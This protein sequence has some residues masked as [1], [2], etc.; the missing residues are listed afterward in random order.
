M[1]HGT[2][3]ALA[4]LPFFLNLKPSFASNDTTD[5]GSQHAAA[6][7]NKNTLNETKDTY[8]KDLTDQFYAAYEQNYFLSKYQDA[9]SESDRRAALARK[10][11]DDIKNAKSQNAKDALQ[12]SLDQVKQKQQDALSEAKN[13]L[14]ALKSKAVGKGSNAYLTSL[15]TLLS[16]RAELAKNPDADKKKALDDANTKV[17]TPPYKNDDRTGVFSTLQTTAQNVNADALLL[18][19]YKT[20]KKILGITVA[21][22]NKR[23]LQQTDKDGLK[24]DKVLSLNKDADEDAKM[25]FDARYFDDE[26][27]GEAKKYGK[28]RAEYEALIYPPPPPPPSP[29][30]SPSPSPDASPVASPSPGGAI[31]FSFDD[32]SPSPSP[33]G[34]N[35]CDGAYTEIS[36][37]L[38]KTQNG[39][40]I[41]QEMLQLAELKMAYRLKDQKERTLENY[42]RTAKDLQT[43][44]NG[45]SLPQELTE[46]FKKYGLTASV[47]ELKKASYYGSSR[48]NNVTAGAMIYYLS[49]NESDDK[50]PTSLKFTEGDAAAVWALG[51]FAE[52][53]STGKTGAFRDFGSNRNLLDFSVRVCQR[54]PSTACGK[55]DMK[56]DAKKIEKD[57]EDL[58]V[59]LRSLIAQTAK[60]YQDSHPN[61]FSPNSSCMV[62]QGIDVNDLEHIKAE[63]SRMLIDPANSGLQIDPSKSKFEKGDLSIHLSPGDAATGAGQ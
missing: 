29:S 41:Y 7:D 57:Y 45:Q 35:D 1:I 63:L 23:V 37:A 10:I 13:G 38:L 56:A 27:A 21:N 58:N 50:I 24:K 2:V 8:Q 19:D 60:A 15:S 47:Q 26:N 25:R 46:A 43:N 32:P 61:C 42:A 44:L 9:V 14:E 34:A 22:P 17:Q 48:I 16:Q 62:N 28:P 53:K 3:I 40:K 11:E 55:K 49:K 18:R 33:V 20:K 54:Y 6:K 30:P 52:Q 4:A 59:K 51:K 36:R 39:P 31:P 12:K 5:A